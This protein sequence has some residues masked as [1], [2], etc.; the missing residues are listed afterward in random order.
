MPTTARQVLELARRHGDREFL[1]HEDE[2]ISF[3]AF[4]RAVLA[5]AAALE[6]AGLA[7]GDRVAI[8]MRNLPEW[9]VVFFG[10]LVAGA[11]A[12]P[13]NAWWT[14][15]ELRHGLADSGSRF[16]FADAERLERLKDNLPATVEQLF[17]A[18]GNNAPGATALDDIL[19]PPAAWQRLPQGALPDIAQDPED[20]ATI[21]YTSG[22]HRHAQGGAG[23][24][25]LSHHQHFR[26]A[27]FHRPQRPSPR[28]SGPRSAQR[29]PAHHPGRPSRFSTSPPASPRWCP[30][31]RRAASWC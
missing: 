28:R 18:R 12:V 1:V 5:A 13:L 2:R 30:M 25:S 7:R 4:G 9:P 20:D 8:V 17:V 31:P 15:G 19:G 10:A 14:A 3:D 11:I 27:L 16:V 26:D 22:H 21:F 24:P 23:H 6:R 29:A